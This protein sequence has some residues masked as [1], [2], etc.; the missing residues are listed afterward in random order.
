MGKINAKKFKTPKIIK[1][2]PIK[3][4]SLCSGS[5]QTGI[6]ESPH[7]VLEPSDYVPKPGLKF[8]ASMFVQENQQLFTNVYTLHASPLG[9]G[10]Y[11]EV[12]L[13]N[14]K[15]TNELRAVKILLK[16]GIPAEEIENKSVLVEVEILKSLDHPNIL[17]VYEYFEDGFKYYIVMEYCK[18]GDLLDKLT[19][20][21]RF[22]ETQAAIVLKQLLSSLNYLHSK[23]IIHRDIKPENLLLCQSENPDELNV[24]LIDFNIS[25]VK[26]VSKEVIGTTDYMAPEV[27]KGNYDE[28]CDVWGAGVILYALISG[29]LPFTGNT[30]EEIEAKI[31]KGNFAIENGIWSSVS[32]ECKDLIKRLLAKNPQ[33][34]FSSEQALS[35][36]WLL[37]LTDSSYDLTT[38][39]NSITRM[40]TIKSSNKL[41]EVFTT[42]MISQLSSNSSNKKLE[43][44]FNKIDKNKDGVISISEI[45][46]ELRN[47]MSETDAEIEAKR[48]I[49]LIDVDGSGKVDYT[50]FLRIA[51]EEESLL[52]KENLK[53]TFAYFDKDNSG[54]IDKNELIAWL[55]TG[56]IIPENILSELIDEADANDDGSIDLAEFEALLL[57]KLELKD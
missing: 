36:R 37:S 38:H 19:Q 8:S 17:K 18:G 48:I 15:I 47:E 22:T 42:F 11:G 44:V 4:G 54:T 1:K 20:L 23:K 21:G 2:S 5:S 31:L 3:M 16:E 6:V 39:K 46:E 13:C 30:D 51:V 27:F 7:N 52:T 9:S 40:R 24:K 29:E 25:I 56:E 34:R 50:E 32:K 28:K 43:Q 35:H 57:D 53:K 41:K 14:H 12:W 33:S 26:T 45:I 49:D 10:A 55:S